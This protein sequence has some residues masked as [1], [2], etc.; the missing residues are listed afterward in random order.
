MNR[1]AAL[2]LPGLLLTLLAAVVACGGETATPTA[3]PPTAV[4]PAE[5]AGVGA[6]A[7]LREYAGRV[8]GGPGAVYAGDLSQLAGPAPAAGLGGLDA[9]GRPDGR[10]PLESLQRHEWIY[11]S[12]YYRELLDKA[13]LLN[14]TPLTSRGEKFEFQYVCNNRT[15]L[16]CQLMA[17]YLIPNV[18]ARTGGQLVINL[19]SLPELGLSGA[20]NMALVRDGTLEMAEIY[21][22]YVTGAAPELEI[23]SLWGMVET[24]QEQY[25]IAAALTPDME[26]LMAAATGGAPIITHNWYFGSDQ[27][28]FCQDK[29]TAP[30]DFRGQR[31]RSHGAALSDWIEGMGAEAIFVDFAEVYAGLERGALDCAITGAY[32]AY[33]QRWYEVTSYMN[34]FLLGLFNDNVVM[35][36][37]A[38][39]RL[40]PDLQAILLEEGARHELEALR[41]AAIQNEVG[42]QQN[43][44]AGLEWAPFSPDLQALSRRAVR[45]QVIPGWIERVGDLS[46]PVFAVFNEKVSPIAGLRIEPDGRVTATE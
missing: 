39:D 44:N 43:L 19:T 41:L 16:P 42:I 13:R 11:T 2:L 33:G 30:A 31:T 17:A 21:T 24:H 27:F 34:G 12:P 45:D 26:R 8:A 14:P 20:D 10:V 23:Q 36:R 37:A 15:L 7:G 3:P 18:A 38:F 35:H 32:S 5:T 46:H 40:P 28:F 29:L 6:A 4:A 22:G 25:A 9:D 1:I